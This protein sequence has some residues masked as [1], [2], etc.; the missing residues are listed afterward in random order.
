MFNRNRKPARERLSV[1]TVW[2]G[3]SQWEFPV[4]ELTANSFVRGEAAVPSFL[5]PPFSPVPRGRASHTSR[6]PR[7]IRWLGERKGTALQS[8]S[9]STSEVPP[10][11]YCRCNCLDIFV[12]AVQLS[13]SK[14]GRKRNSNGNGNG[15]GNGLCLCLCDSLG[16]LIIDNSLVYDKDTEEDQGEFLVKFLLTSWMLYFLSYDSYIKS[17]YTY[18]IGIPYK[19][20]EGNELF[21]QCASW[22][23]KQ[24]ITSPVQSLVARIG[25]DGK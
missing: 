7:V 15:N 13:F 20:I 10:V 17:V 16:T 6:L 1:M 24:N 19:R 11:D 2:Q 9:T 23:L 8:T 21:C 5:F 14:Q 25:N 18:R 12:N 3:N 22:R 4:A